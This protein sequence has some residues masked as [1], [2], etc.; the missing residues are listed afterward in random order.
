[1]A[2]YLRRNRTEM[3]I[4]VSMSALY[5]FAYF[6]RIAV[7]GTIFDE[8]Q[9]SFHTS[10]GAVAWLAALYL[11]IYG[12]TTLLAGVLSDRFGSVKVL[13]A[14]GLIMSVGS[15]LFPL[16]PS[17]GMLYA[18]RALVGLGAGLIYLSIVKALDSLFGEKHFAIFL[19]VTLFLGYSGGLAG[20]FPFE[21]LVNGVGWRMALLTAGIL[22]T[23]A[24]LA[25]A[26]LFRKNRRIRQRRIPL[27]DLKFRKIL[28][29]R[30]SRLLLVVGPV[31]FGVYFLVQATIGKKFLA[32]Y[33]GMSS[34][35]SAT[36]TFVMM[37]VTMIMVLSAGFVSR[38]LENRRKPVI[39]VA[40]G[41]AL[42]SIALLEVCARFGLGR[43]WFLLCYVVLGLST[44]GSPICSVLMKESNPSGS[45]GTAIGVLN[46]ASYLAVAVI[47]NFAAYAMDCFSASA[48]R[49]ATAVIYPRAA[50]ETIFI[51]CFFLALAAFI[52]ALCLRESHGKSIYVEKPPAE[53]RR[54]SGLTSTHQ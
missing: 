29:G 42:F 22:C 30:Q 28:G 14:G 3:L 26:L 35:L 9:S 7:P 23:A 54:I 49:T 12:G 44:I 39:V 25:A 5:F 24:F 15:V 6:Q 50:Y 46:G 52:C 8:L 18:T 40:V 19:G 1:M 45:V 16:S 43:G 47:T 41:L 37:L 53:G 11:Y 38:L 51:G 2:E 17:L 27:S 48:K 4:L 34:A 13:L 32:D 20:T 10:A 33:C 31:T 21:R 36:F